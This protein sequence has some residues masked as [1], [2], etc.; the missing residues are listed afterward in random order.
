M[1]RW[2]SMTGVV[3]G[4]IAIGSLAFSAKPSQSQSPSGFMCDASSGSPATVYQNRQGVREVW[5]NWVSDYFRDSGYDPMT[6]CREVSGRLESYR[7]NKQ[8][9]YVTVGYMNGQRVICTASQVNGRCD[10]LIYTLKPGQDSVRTL[11]QFMGLREGQAGVPSL[12]ESDAMPYIDARPRL[13]EEGGNSV[14]PP[15]PANNQPAPANNRPAPQQPTGGGMRE[16]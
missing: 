2:R 9:K 16:L 1:I 15:A 5:I 14:A 10:G 11:Y 3:M 13:G 7:Q 12:S 8:L 4:A 6:R